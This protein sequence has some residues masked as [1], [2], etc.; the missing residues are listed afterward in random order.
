MLH[1][2]DKT[3]ACVWPW[4]TTFI[5][6]LFPAASFPSGY[7]KL[8]HKVIRS[9]YLIIDAFVEDFC[10][11]LLGYW[12]INWGQGN[13]IIMVNLTSLCVQTLAFLWLSFSVSWAFSENK[14][15]QTGGIINQ[16]F[17]E[18]LNAVSNILLQLQLCLHGQTSLDF[19]LDLL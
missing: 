7:W 15:W 14:R 17:W 5:V 13:F 3:H 10:H 19:T 16:K 2:S 18:Q 1:V 6:L 4:L 12:N 9:H 8:H 11:N